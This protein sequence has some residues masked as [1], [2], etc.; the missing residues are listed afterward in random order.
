[1]GD[2]EALEEERAAGRGLE[3]FSAPLQEF[4]LASKVCE[5]FRVSGF[6]GFRS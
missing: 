4:L 1:M 2:K 5:G 6:R 3:R